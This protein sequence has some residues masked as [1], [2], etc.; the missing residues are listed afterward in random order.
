MKETRRQRIERRIKEAYAKGRR[1]EWRKWMRLCEVCDAE[2][3]AK[4]INK[5]AET[6]KSRL[7]DAIYPKDFESMRNLIDDVVKE[8]KN[9]FN[10]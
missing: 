4:V 8:Q 5:F 3:D 1:D 9:E 6:L 2:H 10:F 7:G